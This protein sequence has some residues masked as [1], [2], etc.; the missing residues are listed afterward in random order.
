MQRLACLGL[1]GQPAAEVIQATAAV[2]IDRLACYGAG[3]LAVAFD[4]VEKTATRWPTPAQVIASLPTY[5]VD[6]YVPPTHQVTADPDS[7]RA[8][9]TKERADKAIAECAE[10]LGVKL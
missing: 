1:E 7:E 10:R 6:P 5:R 4:A 2:W 9:R 8:A 3:R